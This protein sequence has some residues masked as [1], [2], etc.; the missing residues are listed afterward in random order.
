MKGIRYKPIA[1]TEVIDAAKRYDAAAAGLG[2]DFIA[3]V[4]DT[5]AR[6]ASGER[7]G[8]RIA[9]LTRSRI[10]SMWCS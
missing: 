2:D 5:V 4:R 6:A 7:P 10:C 9:L 1:A 3:E 8:V